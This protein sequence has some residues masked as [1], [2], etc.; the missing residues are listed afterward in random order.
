MGFKTLLTEGAFEALI[1]TSY[2]DRLDQ[3]FKNQIYIARQEGK[4]IDV[5]FVDPGVYI[6]FMMGTTFWINKNL[7]ETIKSISVYRDL[8]LKGANSFDKLTEIT[9]LF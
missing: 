9:D 2:L 7:P 4:D 1:D 5:A 8:I 3:F 6:L